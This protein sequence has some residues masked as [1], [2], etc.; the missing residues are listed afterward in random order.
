MINTLFWNIRG[1][2]KK[3]GSSRLKALKKQHKLSLICICEP[4]VDVSNVVDIQLR[5]GFKNVLYNTAN[6]IWVFFDESI[7]ASIVAQSDQHLTLKCTHP[8]F[9][10]EFLVCFVHAIC[11]IDSRTN[12]WADLT[13]VCST[14]YPIIIYGDFNAITSADE[15][16]GGSPF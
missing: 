7:T 8:A 10:K 6:R 12:L 1:I 16:R 3:I 9:H 15:K 14:H 2:R 13:Q 5:L 4:H 11:N